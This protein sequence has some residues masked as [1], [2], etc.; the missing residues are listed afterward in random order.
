M[1]HYYLYPPQNVILDNEWYFADTTYVHASDTL[2]NKILMEFEGAAPIPNINGF[3]MSKF[4]GEPIRLSELSTGCKTILNTV[5]NPDKVFA[6]TE[7]GQNAISY[8]YNLDCDVHVFCE[9]LLTSINR[10][11]NIICYTQSEVIGPK[12]LGDMAK[13]MSRRDLL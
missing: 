2:F 8:L 7:C 3:Y 9:Y 6:L 10:S 4:K 11:A 12:T 1:I 13:E 5:F